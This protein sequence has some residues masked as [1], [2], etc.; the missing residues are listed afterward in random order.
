MIRPYNTW[1]TYKLDTELDYFFSVLL[2]ILL[3]INFIEETHRLEVVVQGACSF[4]TQLF[5]SLTGVFTQ[6]ASLDCSILF[7]LKKKKIIKISDPFSKPKMT[8]NPKVI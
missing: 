3:W 1:Q 7:D 4:N 5:P 6:V 8:Q 2:L